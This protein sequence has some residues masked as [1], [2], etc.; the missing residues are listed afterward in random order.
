M[1]RPQ[2][3]L[4]QIVIAALAAGLAAWF[5]YDKGYDAC[6]AEHAR[7][8]AKANI[9]LIEGERERDRDGGKIADKARDQGDAKAAAA[10]AESHDA[11]ERI[12]VVYRDRWKDA[13]AGSCAMPLDPRV[14][15]EIDA[16]V[17][18]SNGEPK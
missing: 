12:K 9:T 15:A 6:Q 13:P 3:W 18:R 10:K 5:F 4:L 11:G 7:K 17:R 2:L 8:T 14:Q 16:A 1:T